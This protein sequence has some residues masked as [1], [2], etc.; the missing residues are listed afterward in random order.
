MQNTNIYNIRKW[1]SGTDYLVNDIVWYR[2]TSGGVD[3]KFYWYATAD[4]EASVSPSLSNAQW[5]GVKYDNRTTSNKPF[6]FWKPSYNLTVNNQPKVTAH[7][8]GDGY[9]QRVVDGVDNILLQGSVSFDTR[10]AKEARAM[11][12][13]LQ[14]RK[15]QESFVMLLPPPY[16]LEKLYVAGD[17]TTSFN[18][19]D[20]YSIRMNLR[21]VTA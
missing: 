21:E 1:K 12:H 16:N 17:W 3:R 2:L 5:A 11:A 20:N 9:E 19:Y 14:Q 18:F 15:G 6:W 4:H 7:Q 8:F 13:F 10:N